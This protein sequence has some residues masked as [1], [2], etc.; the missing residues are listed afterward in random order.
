MTCILDNQV[1]MDKNIPIITNNLEK[2]VPLGF[3]HVMEHL[4]LHL[5]HEARL[6]NPVQYR[7]MYPFER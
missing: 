2:I 7:R 5:V 1:E 6:R 3:F 4:P